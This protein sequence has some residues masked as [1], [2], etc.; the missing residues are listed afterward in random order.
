[1]I[2]LYLSLSRLPYSPFLRRLRSGPFFFLLSRV[3]D[4]GPRD[5]VADRQWDYVVSGVV[6]V[7]VSEYL[8]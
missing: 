6:S 3:I 8:C 7:G 5:R 2:S 4:D 1:M